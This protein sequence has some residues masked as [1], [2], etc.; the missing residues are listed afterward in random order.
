M[1]FNASTEGEIL[2]KWQEDYL[3]SKANTPVGVESWIFMVDDGNIIM[4]ARI[5][6]LSNE[7]PDSIPISTNPPSLCPSNE[8]RDPVTGI[9]KCKPGYHEDS[10]GNCVPDI[11]QC[12]IGQ[13]L[14]GNVCV[15]DPIVDCAEGQHKDSSGNC[16][17][18]E[19]ICEKG[20]H[21]D[22]VTGKCV[23]DK[24]IP[25][26]INIFGLE[27]KPIYLFAAGIIALLLFTRKTK[28][29]V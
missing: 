18:N 22:T 14:E 27:V 12:P 10:L 29:N 8:V 13:H 15:V 11:T 25:E 1:Y 4:A 5:D 9:C 21:K 7:I 19:V 23:A 6:P 17:P 16:I 28:K 24:I 2:Y 3:E 20:F 26:T